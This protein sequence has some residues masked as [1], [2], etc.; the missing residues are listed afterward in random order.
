[1]SYRPSSYQR[2]ME[3]DCSLPWY[4]CTEYFILINH[5]G[6]TA[7]RKSRQFEAARTAPRY[8]QKTSPRTK[9]SGELVRTS[10]SRRV[11]PGT[12]CPA[13]AY[14]CPPLELANLT[15]H[16]THTFLPALRSALQA[17]PS[18]AQSRCPAR[19]PCTVPP[20]AHLTQAIEWPPQRYNGQWAH[21]Q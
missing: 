5:S 1:M 12:P 4:F 2:V 6:T 19:R 8:L 13:P 17:S 7:A 16:S 9:P 15:I 14:H 11:A 3:R 18:P 21:R 10:R 20:T